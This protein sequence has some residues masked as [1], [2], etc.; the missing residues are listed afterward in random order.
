ML[1]GTVDVAVRGGLHPYIVYAL[2]E[3][4]QVVHRGATLVSPAGTFRRSPAPT[5]RCIRWCTSFYLS[6]T[7]WIYASLP[8]MIASFV[9]R[10]LVVALGIFVLAEL[11]R[12]SRYLAELGVAAF[13]WRR[14]DK[15][16]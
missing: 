10:Y 16:T 6:G 8:P 11:Y 12:F 9:D 5:C 4:M 3:V 15:E 2:L 13:A 7:P 14:R 1:A